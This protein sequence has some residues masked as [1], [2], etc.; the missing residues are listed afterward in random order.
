MVVD[1]TLFVVIGMAL[2]LWKRSLNSSTDIQA[3]EGVCRFYTWK[4]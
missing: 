4:H 1:F 3:D 2:L